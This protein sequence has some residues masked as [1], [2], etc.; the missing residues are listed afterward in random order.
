MFPY[1]TPHGLIMKINKDKGRI[2]ATDIRDDMDFWDWY[3]RR[4]HGSR[5]FMRD[6]VARKSFSKLRGAIAG[7]YSNRMKLKESEI[8][9][10]Q[11][12]MLY[13]LSPEA[14]FRLVQEVLMR[15]R[16]YD[17]SKRLMR[18]FGEQDP[19]NQRVFQFIRQLEKIEVLD[20][21]ILEMEKKRRKGS[22]DVKQALDLA[23][24]YRQANQT[25]HFVSIMKGLIG[26]SN[27]PPQYLYKAA[28]MLQAAKQYDT[29]DEALTVMM[30]RLPAN[31]DPSLYLNVAKMYADAQRAERMLPAIE[32][33]L[34]LRPKDWKAWLDLASINLGLKNLDAARS[35]LIKAKSIGGFQAAEAIRKDRRFAGLLQ[36]ASRDSVDLMN[37]PGVSPNSGRP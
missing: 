3:V 11:A 18:D 12:R 33:Y 28:Q 15:Q 29:M 22:L 25:Q 36:G 20:K 24:L 8:A 7:L 21:R 26:T 13:P 6:V 35:A 9:F 2:P 1:L 16:R 5:K 19:S 31:T 30:K 17:E 10:Q 14:N 27:V 4:L 37:I 23:D 34:K 32:G